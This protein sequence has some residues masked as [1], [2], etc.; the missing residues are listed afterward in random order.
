M[1]FRL[2][3]FHAGLGKEFS[4]LGEIL[5]SKHFSA[6]AKIFYSKHFTA[7][8]TA[9]ARSSRRLRW[10]VGSESARGKRRRF[11]RDADRKIR[12]GNFAG[13]AKSRDFF[14]SEW[15]RRERQNPLGQAQ[16]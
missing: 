13:S 12:R 3:Y 10:R 15:E 4:A 11:E 14:A 8:V 6:L 1:E 2:R 5:H 9:L 16:F 7:L